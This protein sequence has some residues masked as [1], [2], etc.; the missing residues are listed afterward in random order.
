[1]HVAG[2]AVDQA[3][4]NLRVVRN[5]YDAGAS[6]NVEVLDAVALRIQALSNRDDARYEY[7][8]ATLR[9]AQAAGLL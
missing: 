1:M 6:T 5:R 7:A 9:L 2:S 8:L 3:R 4:E